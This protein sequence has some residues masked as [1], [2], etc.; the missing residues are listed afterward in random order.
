MAITNSTGAT[1]K[2][3]RLV[4]SDKD[5]ISE[6]DVIRK[7]GDA[8]EK[9]DTLIKKYGLTANDF[10]G[11]FV[12][13]E[14]WVPPFDNKSHF[15]QGQL[16]YDPKLN[17]FIAIFEPSLRHKDLDDLWRAVKFLRKKNGL[18]SK[19]RVKPSNEDNSLLFY[20]VF[21]CIWILKLGWDEV[22]QLYENNK[23]NYNGKSIKPVPSIIIKNDLQKA[24]LR[25]YKAKQK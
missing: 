17:K 1:Y 6:M 14:L 5:F 3:I 23:L 24:Y 11:V 21:K 8:A 20:A 15:T 7:K 16:T 2:H 10:R 12:W 22:F 4:V 19:K 13:G 25:V 9:R 18:D